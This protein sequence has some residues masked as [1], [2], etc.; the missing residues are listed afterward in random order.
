MLYLLLGQRHPFYGPLSEA[1]DGDEALAQ[2]RAGA[3]PLNQ[4][5]GPLAKAV[6][7]LLAFERADRPSATQLISIL[8]GR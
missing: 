1:M 6:A 2:L 4:Q 3:A 5:G 7:A 8:R